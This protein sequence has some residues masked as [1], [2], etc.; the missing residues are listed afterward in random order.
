MEKFFYDF[1]DGE[2]AMSISDDIAMD[3]DGNPMMRIDENMALDMDTGEVH[4]ISGWSS[5]IGEEI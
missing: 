1:D 4:I 5:D 2:P 3:F